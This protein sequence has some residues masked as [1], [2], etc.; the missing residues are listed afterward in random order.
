MGLKSDIVSLLTTKKEEKLAMIAA[1]ADAF[2][3]VVQAMPEDVP[4]EVT[5][6]QAELATEKSKSADLQTQV[7]SAVA[8]GQEVEQHLNADEAKIDQAKAAIKALLE[9]LSAAQSV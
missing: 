3:A 1:E 8:H 2:I 7:D 9:A 5:E 6:L 4:A